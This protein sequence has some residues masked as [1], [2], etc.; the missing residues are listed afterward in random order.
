MGHK[1]IKKVSLEGAK[2][3]RGRVEERGLTTDDGGQKS[4]DGGHPG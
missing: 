3:Q 4:D 1:I 2:A